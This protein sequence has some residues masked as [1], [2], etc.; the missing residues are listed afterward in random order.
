VIVVDA[1]SG[2]PTLVSGITGSQPAGS[3]RVAWISIVPPGPRELVLIVIAPI[4]ASCSPRTQ[5]VAGPDE[6][7]TRVEDGAPREGRTEVGCV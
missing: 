3:G 2:L 7:S 5:Q 6:G 1:L 4:L